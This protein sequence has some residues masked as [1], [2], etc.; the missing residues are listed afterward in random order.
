MSNI[1][2]KLNK[3]NSCIYYSFNQKRK[4]K[5]AEMKKTVLN[6]EKGHYVSVGIFKYWILMIRNSIPINRIKNRTIDKIKKLIWR[7]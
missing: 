6:K 1:K 7:L 2:H 3:F 4:G 5:G